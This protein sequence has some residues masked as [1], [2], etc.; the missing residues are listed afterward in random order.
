MHTET[1]T[2]NFC[3]N[4]Q[5]KLY[6]QFC[7]TCGQNQKT[8]NR[9]FLAL[10]NEFLEEVVTPNSRAAR[11]LFAL[12][13]RP[14]FLTREYFSGRKARYI[15]PIRLYL[16]MSI[17]FFFL[18]SLTNNSLV[19]NSDGEP[20]QLSFGS[21][22]ATTVDIEWPYLSPEEASHLNEK[23]QLQLNKAREKLE[24]NPGE[25]LDVVIDKAPSVV[26]CLV[27]IFA[28]FLKLTYFT[29]GRYYTEHFVLALHNHSFLFTVL[30]FEE[31]VGVIAPL[32]IQEIVDGAI[33]IWIPIYLFLSLKVTYNEGWF[34]TT[35]KF[36]FLLICYW[37]VFIAVATSAAVIGVL[38]L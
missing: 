5:S 24:N 17:L 16:T 28:V 20:T 31:L 29:L 23:L 1:E 30:L 34:A 36:L 8:I 27:P 38:L 11:T 26:F 3:P 14:G 15:Q 22:E 25:A 37:A 12:S 18:V 21:E 32:A 19:Q 9:H 13:F 10:V 2:E 35:F 7:F 6:G 33:D 4:C